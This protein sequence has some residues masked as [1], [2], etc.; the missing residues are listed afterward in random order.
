[1]AI[2]RALLGNE[3]WK[4][5]G[6]VPALVFLQTVQGLGLVGGGI[7]AGI[8]QRRGPVFGALV[9]VAGGVLF[10]ATIFDSFVAQPLTSLADGTGLSN[11]VVR[12]GTLYG[13]PILYAVLGALGGLIGRVVWQPLPDISEL[14]EPRQPGSFSRRKRRARPG[15]SLWDGQIVWVRV[16]LGSVLAVTGALYTNRFI[17]SLVLLSEGK[18]AV[19]TMLQDQVT[20]AE[21][22]SLSI[23]FGAAVAGFNTPNGLKQGMCVGIGAAALIDVLLVAGFL[24]S[25]APAIYPVL[26]TLFLGPIGGWIGSELLPPVYRHSRRRRS[27][28]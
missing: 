20:Y 13:L 4:D 5:L 17:D 25:S 11:A 7:V 16:A 27:W 12:N 9:G 23:M 15:R 10:L 2:I 8:G 28:L 14:G 21:I 19:A 24:N 18:L 1:M 26:S 6:P 3:A 22:F